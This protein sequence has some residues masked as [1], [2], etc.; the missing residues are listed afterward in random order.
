MRYVLFLVLVLAAAV[1]LMTRSTGAEQEDV[2]PAMVTKVYYLSRYFSREEPPYQLLE[3]IEQPAVFLA[4]E[5]DVA[6][7]YA[8]L[9]D[10]KR[11]VGWDLDDPGEMVLTQDWR[12][13]VQNTPEKIRDFDRAVA[14]VL[15]KSD[16]YQ[17][18]IALA[19]KETNEVPP[20]G[21]AAKSL[22]DR[23][24]SLKGQGFELK[25]MTPASLKTGVAARFT[26]GRSISYISDQEGLIATFARAYD[27][28]TSSLRTG[29][30]IS[31]KA[32]ETGEAVLIDC[33]LREARF[34]G[35]KTTMQNGNEIQLPDVTFNSFRRQVTFAEPGTQALT[36][37]S[38]GT[39]GV[40]LI[41]LEE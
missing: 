25:W 30:V 23:L 34:K 20:F 26:S 11:L 32:S 29:M 16:C 33:S 12:L 19:T 13:I 28:V 5:P 18:R 10:I 22:E 38:D 15:P 24:V 37:A 36:Y 3:I 8:A 6:P 14:V 7:V 21:P 4:D 17:V 35:M 1:F 2:K 27:P 41:E 39:V 9:E 31:L 40:L